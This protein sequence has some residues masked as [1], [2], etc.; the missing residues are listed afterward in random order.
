MNEK[1]LMVGFAILLI[2]ALMIACYPF[3]R[4]KQGLAC[5]IPVFIIAAAMGYWRWGAWS[6]LETFS[7]QQARKQQI[8]TLLATIKGPDELVQKL[9]SRLND[10]PESARGWYLLGRL[11]ASTNQWQEASEAF[12][13]SRELNADDELVQINYI[14][15]LWQL[16]QQQLSPAIKQLLAEVLKKNPQQPDALAFLAMDA[17]QQGNFKIAIGYWEQLLKMAPEQSEEAASLRK[18]IAKARQQ[19]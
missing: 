3:R 13:K 15:S 16:N 12:K 10:S 2:V 11:Y 18:A 6:A 1:G 9:K 19:S 17:Y 8:K 5:I 14:Q 7:K 4:S